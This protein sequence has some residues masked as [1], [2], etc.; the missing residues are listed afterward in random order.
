V[1]NACQLFSFGE[2]PVRVLMQDGQPWF[3]AMDVCRVLE[4]ANPWNVVAAL[5]AD[6]KATL[7][8]VEGRPGSGPQ[9]FNIISES[10]LYALIFKSRKAKAKAFRKW[11]TG[12]VLPALRTRGA[13]ALAGADAVSE[14]EEVKAM[15]L[16]TLRGLVAGTVDAERGQAI[17]TGARIW[18]V[19]DSRHRRN[20]RIGVEHPVPVTS[21]E[22]VEEWGRL[23]A[24]MAAGDLS[25][26]WTA[27]ELREIAL[28][29]GIFQDWL[30][31]RDSDS[32][33]VRSRFGKVCVAM[34]GRTFGEVRFVAEGINRARRYRLQRIV[35]MLPGLEEVAH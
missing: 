25:K 15:V 28:Q 10:G 17:L 19:L 3:M 8:N 6:E 29:Q 24:V 18:N 5:D 35:E 9:R 26:E 11:V 2:E 22:A 32:A 31:R 27:C 30:T 23:V 20:G 16:A 4:I 1:N 34:A 21:H 12:E 33:A 14:A 13:Y 7:H